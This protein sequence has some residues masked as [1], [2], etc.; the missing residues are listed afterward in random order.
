MYIFLNLSHN[1]NIKAYK[2]WYMKTTDVLFLWFLL[3]QIDDIILL[4]GIYH[5]K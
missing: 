2:P 5:A 4:G 1:N 3:F